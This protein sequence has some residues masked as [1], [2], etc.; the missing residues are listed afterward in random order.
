M[1][2]TSFSDI[3]LRVLVLT[4]GAPEGQRLTTRAIADGVGAPYHHVT[5]TVARLS[6]LGLVTA[7]RGQS[8]GVTITQA[9]LDASV[10]AILRELESKSAMVACEAPGD[11]CP[12]DHGC[13]LRVALGRA[14]EAF[15][16]ELDGVRIRDVVSE[17]QVGPVL[18]QLGLRPPGALGTEAPGPIGSDVPVGHCGDMPANS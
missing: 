13:R 18:V 4:G 3:A 9:G 16:R 11:Q 6:G 10:G 12:L 17:R 2:L 8:G 14:R 15:Y 5:K 7:V 1:R